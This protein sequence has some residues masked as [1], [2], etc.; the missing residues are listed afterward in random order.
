M[1]HTC[2]I[3]VMVSFQPAAGQ[4]PSGLLLSRRSTAVFQGEIVGTERG[5][6]APMSIVL[7]VAIVTTVLVGS[8]GMLLLGALCVSRCARLFGPAPKLD[9]ARAEELRLREVTG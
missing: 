3:L 7:L 6:F 9:V 8:L 2:P 1:K 5:L 4:W